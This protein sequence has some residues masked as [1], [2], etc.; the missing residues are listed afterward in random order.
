MNFA[1]ISITLCFSLQDGLTSLH[2]A[3]EKNHEHVVELLLYK[4]AYVD[5]EAKVSW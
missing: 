2:I 3:S 4:G 5:M 1:E